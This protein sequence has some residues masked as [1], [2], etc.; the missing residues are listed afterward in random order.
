MSGVNGSNTRENKNA[1]G[2][3]QR[4]REREREYMLEGMDWGDNRDEHGQRSP[5]LLCPQMGP[6][7]GL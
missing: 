5:R 2:R 6:S 1:R 3:E 4:G 7:P